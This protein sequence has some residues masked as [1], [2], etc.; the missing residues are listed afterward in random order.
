MTGGTAGEAAELNHR[1][2][3]TLRA[4]A[5]GAAE[6]TLSVE[7]DLFVDGLACCDQATVHRLARR[8]FIVAQRQ[9]RAG[10]RVPALITDA[11]LVALGVETRRAA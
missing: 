11:G 7:P 4:V 6:I 3:A 8:G 5:R 9:G 2:R 1:E 10:E